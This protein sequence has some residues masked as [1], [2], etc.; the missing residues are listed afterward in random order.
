MPYKH[1]RV[2]SIKCHFS[3]PQSAFNPITHIDT[4]G[5]QRNPTKILMTDVHH[6]KI[7]D[8]LENLL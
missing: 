3:K 2:F 4:S 5:I 6:Y 8:H 1:Y 7:E